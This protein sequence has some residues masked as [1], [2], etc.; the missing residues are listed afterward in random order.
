MK[1]GLNNLYLYLLINEVESSG[2][3]YSSC[4]K[5]YQLEIIFYTDGNK[6]KL[7]K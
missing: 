6:Q 1:D 5:S 2:H 4:R 7:I 3:G